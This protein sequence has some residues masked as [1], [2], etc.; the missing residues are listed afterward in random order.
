MKIKLTDIV[1][2]DSI[3][4]RS[5]P[6]EY[7][8]QRMLLAYESGA[9]FPPIIIEAGTYRLV[10]GRH[11]Y[12]TYKRKGTETV[13]VT[14]KSYASEADL[15]ADAVSLNIDHGM[16]LD[17]YSVRSSIAR[18]IE[19]GFELPAIG[20]IVRIPVETIGVIVKGFAATPEG[21]AIALKG[22]LRHMRGETL[23]ARQIEVNRSYAGGKASF[24]AKQIGDLLES[25]LWPRTSPSFVEQ[26]DRLVALWSA[27]RPSKQ[28]AA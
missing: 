20:S 18:L 12:E 22:G 21:Q 26:M 7:N 6:N 25:D 28:D 27:A 8:I 4:P 23:S 9:K 11:R 1:I 24:Y 15:F 13:A 10:D 5:K 14:E 17:Q 3:Y 2:D 19:L 16:A